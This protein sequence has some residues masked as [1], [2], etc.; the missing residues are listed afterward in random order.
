M[1]KRL[2]VPARPRRMSLTSRPI[3]ILL[4]VLLLL[5]NFELYANAAS[6]TCIC[7][8]EYDGAPPLYPH[9]A[10]CG[11]GAELAEAMALSEVRTVDLLDLQT[12]D[13]CGLRAYQLSN[14]VLLAQCHRRSARRVDALVE[15]NHGLHT[16][17]LAPGARAGSVLPVQ[18]LGGSQRRGRRHWHSPMRCVRRSALERSHSA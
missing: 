11:D 14:Q 17:P 18:R 16:H 7:Q 4:F 8:A 12:C 2:T 9:P 1:S 13:L 15:K 10:T 3:C 5:L 6:S